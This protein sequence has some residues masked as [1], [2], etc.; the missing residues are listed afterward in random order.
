M[1]VSATEA[2]HPRLPER[3]R[4]GFTAIFNKAP[5]GMLGCMLAGLTNSAFFA[6]M[7]V[8]CTEIGLSLQQLS[9][10][11]STTVFC[12]LAAQWT[13]GVMSDRFDRALVLTLV[14]IAMAA[15]SGGM[16]LFKDGAFLSLAVKM[17]VWGALMFA[18]YPISVARAHDLFGGRDTV[19]VSS[20]L[21]LAYSIGA[22]ASPLLASAAMAALH[23]PFGLFA[24]W[25]LIHIIFAGVIFVFRAKEKI[26]HVP[27]ADQV[28]FIPMKSTT[29]IVLALDPRN[30]IQNQPQPNREMNA[31][32]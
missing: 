22:C 28:A 18:V 9:G 17:G 20:G 8:V 30:E 26:P 16:F 23:D 1:P 27:V 29:P 14:V 2:T 32:V 24:F 21:L 15:V 5:L 10:I 31:G 4:I 25:C 11:M 12:G 6:M 13:V 7:P 19:A 3:K